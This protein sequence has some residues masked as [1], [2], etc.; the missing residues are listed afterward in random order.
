MRAV[1][2]CNRIL[3]EARILALFFYTGRLG[4]RKSSGFLPPDGVSLQSRTRGI[5]RSLRHASIAYELDFA[6]EPIH[7]KRLRHI[8]GQIE[9]RSALADD[10]DGTFGV[11]RHARI[12]FAG[13]S[14]PGLPE[15]LERVRPE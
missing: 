13:K 14:E 1:K 3:N 4:M 12:V 9:F 15:R 5:S 7:E 8:G 2:F 6:V 10:G 11:L